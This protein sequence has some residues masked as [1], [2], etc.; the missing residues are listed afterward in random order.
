[1]HLYLINFILETRLNP[2]KNTLVEEFLVE[3]FQSVDG[4]ADLVVN[5][6][7]KGT[8]VDVENFQTLDDIIVKFFRKV[9]LNPKLLSEKLSRPK[10]H[11]EVIDVT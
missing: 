6:D 1:M 11:L 3:T 7:D 9:N 10:E 2:V 5:L 4:L 8:N